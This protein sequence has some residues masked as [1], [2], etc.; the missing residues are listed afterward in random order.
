MVGRDSLMGEESLNL[1][2]SDTSTTLKKYTNDRSKLPFSN[3]Q[4]RSSFTTLLMWEGQASV[5]L[6]WK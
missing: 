1:L 3:V 4:V 5:S 6:I 2:K